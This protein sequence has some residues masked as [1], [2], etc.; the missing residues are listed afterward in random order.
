MIFLKGSDFENLSFEDSVVSKMEYD[1]SS[2]ALKIFVD[3]AYWHLDPKKIF[4]EGYLLF[5]DWESISND[6]WDGEKWVNCEKQ[7]EFFRDLLIFE[8]AKEVVN[9]ES[10]R[11]DSPGWMRWRIVNPTCYGEFQESDLDYYG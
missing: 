2:K 11:Q 3:I 10:W 7:D 4:G 5:K 1:A 6:Y 9:M 8:Y